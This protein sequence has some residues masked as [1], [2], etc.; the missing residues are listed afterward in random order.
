MPTEGSGLALVKAVGVLPREEQL[1]RALRIDADEDFFRVAP[2]G[3]LQGRPHQDY[4]AFCA[5][6]PFADGLPGGFVIVPFGLPVE[7]AVLQ[8]LATTLR[9]YLGG[10]DVRMEA[11]RGTEAAHMRLFRRS[12]ERLF[13]TDL[14]DTLT[15]QRPAGAS[16]VMGVTMV[17]LVGGDGSPTAFTQVEDARTGILS[18]QPF[19]S[20][21]AAEAGAGGGTGL[22]L[23]LTVIQACLH[24]L[25]FHEC[26]FALCAMNPWEAAAADAAAR[27]RPPPPLPLC[28]VCL[29]KLSLVVGVGT[30]LGGGSSG[31][32]A[33]RR[34]DVVARYK[35]LAERC[36]GLGIEEYVRWF[37]ERVMAITQEPWAVVGQGAAACTDMALDGGG[38]GGGI[39]GGGGGGGCSGGVV[40]T[41]NEDAPGPAEQARLRLLKSRRPRHGDGRGSRRHGA[42][43]P[44]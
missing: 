9:C 23:L 3:L 17:E 21:A 20:A 32:A 29:R 12:G 35:S 40:A 42:G 28:P 19:F 10:L 43:P 5:S 13:A 6:S 36:R 37:E 31:G 15:R 24:L 44:K 39:G 16:V 34:F 30:S 8:S 18:L 1:R 38:G 41:A 14:L 22:P 27:S 25:G 2:P 7:H 33:A 11:V 26:G 4:A